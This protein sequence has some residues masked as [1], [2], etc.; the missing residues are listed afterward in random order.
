MNA[1]RLALGTAQ[2]GMNYGIA[3][4]SGIPPDNELSS[5]LALARNKQIDTIDT[6]AAYGNAEQ[7]LG[8]AGLSGF[9][10]VSKFP[11]NGNPAQSVEE[12]L[13]ALKINKLHGFI[14]H[15]ADDLL[16]DK[17]IW[18]SLLKMQ[19]EGKTERIGFSL[20]APQQLERCLNAGYV[21]G[22]VQFPYSL[23][24]RRFEPWFGELKKLG[25]E[26]HTRSAFLQGLYFL[27]TVPERLKELSE[28]LNQLHALA[29]QNK[30]AL[31]ELA[32]AFV[33]GDSRIDRV[34]IGV[35]STQ[36]LQSNL[37]AAKKTLP[38]ELRNAVLNIRVANE[39]LLN[40][41]KW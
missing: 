24:D 2:L 3:N 37:D 11:A 4:Q 13:R 6:A 17:A 16:T 25:C 19:Q 23:L 40:P 39:D 8:K 31:E 28:S 18:N 15:N 7:R 34:V 1:N 12:S 14:A 36:Q 26:I 20:Y 30:I 29:V 33:L 32:L 5:I 35:E 38:D 41:S 22:L 9:K 10:I 27:E 21:P